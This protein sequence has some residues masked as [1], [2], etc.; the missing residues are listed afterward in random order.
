MCFL[1]DSNVP[2]AVIIIFLLNIISDVLNYF[3][4]SG[5]HIKAGFMLN[6]S[7]VFCPILSFIP[8]F[9]S[10]MCSVRN[11][12][13]FFSYLCC[14]EAFINFKSQDRTLKM[15]TNNTFKVQI[16]VHQYPYNNGVSKIP[17]IDSILENS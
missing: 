7:S 11:I 1:A 12:G 2:D 6:F 13:G 10:I 16:C 5:E 14:R 17:F 9:S 4:C 15:L 8:F 3:L